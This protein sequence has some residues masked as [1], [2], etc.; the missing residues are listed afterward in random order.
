[1]N[2]N[3]NG[4][5]WRWG[6]RTRTVLRLPTPRRSDRFDRLHQFGD[7]FAF[8]GHRA[9]DGAGEAFGVKFL[10]HAVG[11]GAIALVDDEDVGDL[12]DAGLDGLHIVAHAGD[13]HHNRDLRHGGDLDFVL[14]DADGFDDDV[15]PAGGVHEVRQIG[16]SARQAAHGAAGGHGTDEDAGVGVVL[17]HADAIA[18][19]GAAGDAAAGVHGED[20]DC[21]APLAQLPG[22][23]VHQRAFARAGRAGDADDARLAGEGLEFTQGFQGLGIAVLDSGGQTRQR[24][25]VPFADFSRQL[26]HRVLRN[27]RAIRTGVYSKSTPAALDDLF[28]HRVPPHGALLPVAFHRHAA[29]DGHA[30]ADFKRA[31]GLR[32]AADGVAKVL[33]VGLGIAAC[34]AGHLIAVF[35]ID[36]LGAILDGLR[37]VRDGAV[38]AQRVFGDAQLVVAETG[39]PGVEQFLFMLHADVHGVG[40]F[41]AIL[42]KV[43]AAHHGDG[44]GNLEIHHLVPEG[45]LV[46]HV[47]VHVAA[48]VVPEEAPV[49]VAVGVEIHRS[50]VAQEA[51]PE[52]VFGRHIGIDGPRPLRF[53]VRRI[54]VH[55]AVDG[56]DLAH[57][58]RLVEIDGVPNGAGGG[59]LMADLH[60]MPAGVLL[61]SR[62]H[63]FG[64]V[65]GERH[66]LFLVDVLATGDGGGEVLAVQMLRGGDEDGV[67]ILVIQQAAIV[68][69]G[70]SGRRDLLDI[71]QAARIDVGGADAIHVLAGER[72]LQDFDTARARTDDAEADTLVRAE[73]IAGRQRAGQTGSDMADEITARLHGKRTPWT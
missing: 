53:A 67:D 66:G 31:V 17:L 65:H 19:N 24:A 38:I 41:A 15:I 23:G 20:G 33:H 35:S 30:E 71:F 70:L 59:P 9:E 27:C 18:Q 73:G 40:H 6:G 43:D 39:V 57:Q 14:P 58:F 12:H 37:G 2:S 63:A 4:R 21:L 25:R 56:G 5:D 47:L 7:T 60:G 50:G 62:A 46:A 72:L 28:L 54:A 13:Q 16:R 69:V 44:A 22:E 1:M 49:D 3:S 11:A 48:G 26:G 34:D 42:P 36:L 55:V 61:E 10:F 32:A 8:G 51:L 45:K 64:V 52:D 29:G 68:Q